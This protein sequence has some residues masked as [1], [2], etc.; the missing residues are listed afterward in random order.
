MLLTRRIVTAGENKSLFQSFRGLGRDFP[1][2]TCKSLRTA[3]LSPQTRRAPSDLQGRAQVDAQL[4]PQPVQTASELFLTLAPLKTALQI[5][6]EA[7]SAEGGWPSEQEPEGVLR[8][9]A[10]HGT[11]VGTWRS[12]E[13]PPGLLP[14]SLT[15]SQLAM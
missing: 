3:S 13:E 6:E 2:N 12:A 1:T 7:A 15:G 11:G 14:E 4:A 5:Q 9:A 10:S 8:R